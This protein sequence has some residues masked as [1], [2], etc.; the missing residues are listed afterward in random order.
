MDL[1]CR[2]GRKKS[3]CAAEL[4]VVEPNATPH[5]GE[6]TRSA[7]SPESAMASR[8]DSAARIPTRPMV[9]LYLRGI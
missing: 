3:S 2:M 9:R 8:T 6:A 5:E 7:D 1:S 4:P